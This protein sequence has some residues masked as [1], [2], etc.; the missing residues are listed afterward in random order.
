M[1][2]M[3]AGAVLLLVLVLS[4]C[5][6]KDDPFGGAGQ[7]PGWDKPCGEWYGTGP[8]PCLEKKAEGE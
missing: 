2:T 1:K 5:Q 8:D 7:G 3:K 4:A 6:P